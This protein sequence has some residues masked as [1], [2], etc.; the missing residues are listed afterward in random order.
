MDKAKHGQIQIPGMTPHQQEISSDLLEPLPTLP[1]MNLLVTTGEAEF[2]KLQI[3]HHLVKKW[4]AD[5]EFGD[6][7]GKWLDGFCEKYSVTEESQPTS[8]TTSPQKTT[9]GGTAEVVEPSPKRLK[10][11]EV[12]ADKIFENDLIKDALL[13]DCKLGSKDSLEFPNPS[14]QKAFLGELDPARADPQEWCLPDWLWARQF[15]AFQ[16]RRPIAREGLDI[17]DSRL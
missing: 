5:D 13:F 14:R 15:Q 3:P 11:D 4:R 12:A 1:I 16:G 6:E 17:Y 7:F 2:K 10:A 9:A 8:E